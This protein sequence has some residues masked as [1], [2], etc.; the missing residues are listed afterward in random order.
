MNNMNDSWTLRSSIRCSRVKTTLFILALPGIN[1]GDVM[2]AHGRGCSTA[3]IY[4]Q[5]RLEVEQ[6]QVLRVLQ[7]HVLRFTLKTVTSAS[8]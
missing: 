4:Q 6:I 3:G 7:K 8:K 2:G 5:I 1:P